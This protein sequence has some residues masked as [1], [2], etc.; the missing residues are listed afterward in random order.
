MK[1]IITGLA[2]LLAM[3]SITLAFGASALAINVDSNSFGS[4]IPAC[5]SN[6][7]IANN[8]PVCKDV[9]T[10]ATSK[11]NP[12]IN[13]IKDVINLLSYAVGV[14]VVFMISVSAIMFI[15][16]GGESEKVSKAKNGLI[17][18]VIGVLVVSLAQIIVIFVLDK[19]K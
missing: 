8:T 10:Q 18:A 4:F 17:G 2:G 11:Q 15:T 7:G 16:S 12:I 3:L 5:S 6:N 19:V 9:N 13:I 14:I 1:T